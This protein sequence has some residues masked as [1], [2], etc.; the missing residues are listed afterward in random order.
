MKRIFKWLPALLACAALSVACSKN[1]EPTPGP[2]TG[3][4]EPFDQPQLAEAQTPEGASIKFVAADLQKMEWQVIP[5]AECPAYRVELVMKDRALNDLWEAQKT[6]PELTFEQWAQ[7]TMFATD[8][9]GAASWE[10]AIDGESTPRDFSSDMTIFQGYV[11]PDTEYYVMV[12]G[13]LSADGNNPSEFTYLP[14]KTANPGELIGNPEVEL[15]H[16]VNHRYTR[17]IAIPNDDCPYYNL[18]VLPGSHVKEYLAQEQ[19]SEQ[20]LANVI[21][22]FSLEPISGEYYDQALDWGFNPD[23]TWEITTIAVARDGNLKANPKLFMDTYTVLEKDPTKPL[24]DYEFTFERC[25]AHVLQFRVEFDTATTVNAYYCL[26]PNS[27]GLPSNAEDLVKNGG[28]VVGPT[29]FEQIQYGE[30][31]T[32]YTIYLTARNDQSDIL[33]MKEHEVC[34]TKSIGTFDQDP[35]L[36]E[37]TLGNVAKTQATINY[38]PTDDIAC[39]FFVALERGAIY[40]D[41]VTGEE[42]TDDLTDPKYREK[43]REY[44]MSNG[45][46]FTQNTTWIAEDDWNHFT[47]TGMEPAKSYT[48]LCM[49]ETWD[50]NFVDVQYINF[51]TSDNLG[52]DKPAVSFDME[53]S[54]AD[55]D[56]MKWQVRFVPNEDVTQMYF[57]ICSESEACALLDAGVDA[58]MEEKYVAW[59]EY[60]LG[61]AGM[62]NAGVAISL[63]PTAIYDDMLALAIGYGATNPET[64]TPYVSPLAV[65]RLDYDTHEVVDLSQ[66]AQSVEAQALL[67][68]LAAKMQAA[69]TQ[70]KVAKPLQGYTDSKNVI[71]RAK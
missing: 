67:S 29:E 36:F 26:K 21:S 22:S 20:T 15:S 14:I 32:H 46:I 39:W 62:D 7:Q 41:P 17:A 27:A 3:G 58:P 61:E 53:Q 54:V 51:T 71:I 19:F 9:S 45:N 55:W 70:R 1:D 38:K 37:A 35:S 16:Q 8:G 48:H 60:V 63:G 4:E 11:F 64:N 42:T 5:G 49:A 2:G 24:P 69:N 50:G 31:D 25:S 65:L 13:C 33:E 52:G 6:N 43:A 12:W 47:F 23:P 44:L 30:P 28:W 66:Q 57:C 10:G 56:N 34:T 18:M 68:K 40:Y 59:S